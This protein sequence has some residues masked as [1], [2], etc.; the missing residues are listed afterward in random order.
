MLSVPCGDTMAAYWMTRTP[1]A[2]LELT[3]DWLERWNQLKTV[4]ASVSITGAI[5]LIL[6]HAKTGGA[7]AARH[8]A[9]RGEKFDHDEQSGVRVVGRNHAAVN[10][11]GPLCNG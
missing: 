4:K 3:L 10:L 9:N 6:N 8:P 2:I 11:H 1:S 7:V 5:W